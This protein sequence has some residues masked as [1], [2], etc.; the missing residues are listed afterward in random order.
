VDGKG[1]LASSLVAGRIG[2][3]GNST[4]A[5]AGGDSGHHQPQLPQPGAIPELDEEE[6]EQEQAQAPHIE[7]SPPHPGD[8]PG[9]LT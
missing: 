5:A 4:A 1:R 8:V 3:E 9:V 7:P 2:S 6:E